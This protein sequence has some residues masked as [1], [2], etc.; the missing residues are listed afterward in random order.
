MSIYVHTYIASECSVISFCC[1]ALTC[2]VHAHQD[3]LPSHQQGSNEPLWYCH[4]AD[5]V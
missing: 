5:S 1:L 3:Q 2:T 4:G